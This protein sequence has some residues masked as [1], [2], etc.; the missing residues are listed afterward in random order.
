MAHQLAVLSMPR[1]L[2]PSSQN[3]ISKH[4]LG[5]GAASQ[6]LAHDEYQRQ[7]RQPEREHSA[8]HPRQ[9]AHHRGLQTR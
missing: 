1:P 4:V 6:R 7:Q 8:Q 2:K 5:I 9:C 3:P